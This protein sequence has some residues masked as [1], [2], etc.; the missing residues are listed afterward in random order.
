MGRRDLGTCIILS[1][2]DTTL[3]NL[4]FNQLEFVGE[5]KLN[6]VRG[7]FDFN[8]KR[9]LRRRIEK[10]AEKYKSDLAVIHTQSDIFGDFI[11][12]ISYNFGLYKYK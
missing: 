7:I 9:K 8:I 3:L 6:P 1:S 4:D 11:D 12:E 10:I 5:V 2:E